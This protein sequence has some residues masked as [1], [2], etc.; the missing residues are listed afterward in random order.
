MAPIEVIH[1]YRHL[2]RA[3]L[4]A[5][6]RSQPASTNLRGLLR[7]AFRAKDAKLD[8]RGVRRTVWFLNYASK[9]LGIE[10]RVV[11]NML[12]VEYWKMR[13]AKDNAPSWTDLQNGPIKTKPYVLQFLCS[14][15]WRQR[16]LADAVA[17]LWLPITLMLTMRRP[18]RW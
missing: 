9:E 1:A 8:E 12:M 18:L 6:R 14:S 2:Y 13:V 10:H 3:G 16:P 5:V 15:M 7:R 17:G 4:R 11:K